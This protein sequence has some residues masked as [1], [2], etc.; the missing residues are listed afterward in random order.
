MAAGT[1][2]G[3]N[4]DANAF[5]ALD[6][7]GDT[8]GTEVLDVEVPNTDAVEVAGVPKVGLGD[9]G[10]G[11][12]KVKELELDDGEPKPEKLPNF[13]TGGTYNT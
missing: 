4:T 2:W 5:V 12:V 8:V 7:E 1:D 13:G 9:E 3:D 11:E 6:A 10:A